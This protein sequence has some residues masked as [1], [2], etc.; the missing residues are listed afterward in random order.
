MADDARSRC[1]GCPKQD[2]SPRD[3][4][5]RRRVG[6]TG[7]ARRSPL[8]LQSDGDAAERAGRAREISPG[9]RSARCS[10]CRTSSS[11]GT[12]TASTRCRLSAR[13]PDACSTTARGRSR[14]GAELSVPQLRPSTEA[15]PSRG[16]PPTRAAATLR[17]HHRGRRQH[18]RRRKPAGLRRYANARELTPLTDLLRPLSRRS[19]LVSRLDRNRICSNEKSHGTALCPPRQSPGE[20]LKVCAWTGPFAGRGDTNCHSV[21]RDAA[22]RLF[23]TVSR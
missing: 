10:S 21:G 13:T 20:I 11:R 16:A 12:R 19:Q 14:P 9:Y 2:R 4:D 23:V 6:G 18:H 7:G 8:R 5:S 17:R 3:A 15:A 1:S 22:A